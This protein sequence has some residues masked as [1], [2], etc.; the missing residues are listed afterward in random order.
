MDVLLSDVDEAESVRLRMM[1]DG[2]EEGWN[3]EYLAK[4]FVAVLV[5]YDCEL[6]HQKTFLEDGI[7]SKY[8]LL[9]RDNENAPWEIWDYSMM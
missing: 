1:Y 8:T 2:F 4:N 3:K 6:D 7:V 9:V 5:S